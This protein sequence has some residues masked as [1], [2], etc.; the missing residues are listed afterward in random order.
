LRDHVAAGWRHA[1]AAPA[2]DA[3]QA[4]LAALTVVHRL[5]PF[6]PAYFAADPGSPLFSYAN[7]WRATLAA[8]TEAA[9][10][11][12]VELAPPAQQ[13]PLT[14]ALLTG[15]LKN[16]V[17]H[18]FQRRLDIR[19][20]D[21]EDAAQDQEPF[22]INALENW[23]LQD[24]LIRVQRVAVDDA[25]KQGTPADAPRQAALA[26][27]LA[28][29]ERRG[30]L[31]HRAFAQQVADKLAE[32][33]EKLFGNYQAALQ[34][35]PQAEGD[36]PLDH[37]AGA[38]RLQDWL[39]GMRRN[40]GGE[41]CRLVLESSGVV[42]PS[43][44]GWRYDKL[45][46]HWAAHIAGHLDGDKFATWVVSKAGTAK[47]PP[48]PADEVIDAWAV[49]LQAC[50][51]GMRRPLRFSVDCACAWLKAMTR[52]DKNHPADEGGREAVAKAH[53]IETRPARHR[54]IDPYLARAWPDFDAFWADGE[55]FKRWAQGLLGP[56]RAHVGEPPKDEAKGDAE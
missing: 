38:L 24:E 44:K 47:F 11:A 49:L 6:H 31:P 54:N 23:Q 33:M 35:W 42:T 56:L 41:R 22:A 9:S 16:P 12:D 13:P 15:F 21:D 18:F 39:T 28:R 26:A 46:P 2:T 10:P 34:A 7:E 20:E 27:Q 17:R 8:R 14:L 32:P 5:Q 51:E 45:L 1:N 36:Q 43:P 50:E 4:L 48:L 25:V 53:A 30:E 3:G 19:F 52:S 55:E 40:A 29:I 37:A